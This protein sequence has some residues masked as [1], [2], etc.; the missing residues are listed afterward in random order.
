MFFSIDAVIG[1]R[2]ATCA[3]VLVSVLSSTVALAAGYKGVSA[4]A[5]VV[6]LSELEVGV[7]VSGIEGTVVSF[8]FFASNSSRLLISAHTSLT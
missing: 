6:E 5:D 4:V 8:F 2:R 7:A 1:R 3:L